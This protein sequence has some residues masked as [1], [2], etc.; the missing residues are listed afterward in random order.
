MD[1]GYMGQYVS[2]T[3]YNTS[4]AEAGLSYKAQEAGKTNTDT[5]Q[6]VQPQTS[7]VTGST[8]VSTDRTLDGFVTA[9][10]KEAGLV[11]NDRTMSLVRELLEQHMPVNKETLVAYNRLMTQNPGVD[12][13]TLISMQKNNISITPVMI[14]QFE[15]YKAN[16]HQLMKDIGTVAEDMTNVLKNLFSEDKNA[17][18]SFLDG[19]GRFVETMGGDKSEQAFLQGV[20]ENITTA[21]HHTDTGQQMT[22]TVV[23]SGTTEMVMSE[24]AGET[25]ATAPNIKQELA[26]NENA[27]LIAF[28]SDESEFFAGNNA[29]VSKNTVEMKADFLNGL[30][31]N[32]PDS[33]VKVTMQQIITGKLQN[34]T[35]HEAF[36]ISDKDFFDS[37]AR[38]IEELPEDKAAGFFEKLDTKDFKK[39]VRE[40]LDD[41]V[42]MS[43][44]E[45]ADKEKAVKYYKRLGEALSEI[46]ETLGRLGEKAQA[47][48][49]GKVFNEMTDNASFMNQI[50][51][52]IPYI[53]LPIKLIEDKAHG[54]F[55]VM[56]R[57]KAFQS[58]ETL[59]AF[60]H[61][62]MEHL[63]ELDIM[64]KLKD[65]LLD[66]DIKAAKKEV[67]AFIES[68]LPRLE[69]GLVVKGY[70]PTM[71]VGE[72]E[73][74]FDFE[75][76]FLE[77]DSTEGTI[78]RYSFDMKV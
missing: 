30:I 40:A 76:D 20:G 24:T 10:L 61:L 75:K 69:K 5:L 66:I 43:R 39:I 38:I 2:G 12:A 62:N 27:T 1:S 78:G 33:D 64:V 73:K 54:D 37:L 16:E 23:L 19:I 72:K 8:V 50:N 70:N 60:L 53:Q 68:N 34:P 77:A 59:T 29:D 9:A 45:A 65:R 26:G 6:V 11:S 58:G 3:Y 52:W 55:Y 31:Q 44:E 22:A 49:V 35:E 67:V 15:N 71:S 56:K 4:T 63:G 42:F 21:A 18:A 46:T 14:E 47:S 41:A 57:K 48:A 74:A 28:S 25:A 13:S 7:G 32:L 17:A 51:E 36:N